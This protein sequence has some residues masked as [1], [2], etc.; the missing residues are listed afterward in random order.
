MVALI[1]VRLMIFVIGKQGGHAHTKVIKKQQNKGF[2]TAKNV[3]KS[4]CCK[5]KKV[6]KK[7]S[8]HANIIMKINI[9]QPLD[10][11]KKALLS[12]NVLISLKLYGDLSKIIKKTYVETQTH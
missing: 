11:Y 6:T 5:I 2:F 7:G 9:Y 1:R 4:L 12:L 8:K 10:N 3:Y